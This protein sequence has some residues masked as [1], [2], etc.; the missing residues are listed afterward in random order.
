M[1]LGTI[2]ESCSLL[3]EVSIETSLIKI[4]PSQPKV[5]C[6]IFTEFDHDT[7]DHSRTLLLSF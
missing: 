1:K 7:F 6:G 5:A 2:N 4:D 3:K